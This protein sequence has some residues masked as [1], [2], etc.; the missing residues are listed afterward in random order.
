[1]ELVAYGPEAWI[2][3]DLDEPWEWA[4]AVRHAVIPGVIE[5][6]PGAHS[7]AVLCRRDRAEQV[8]G[9]L[10][11]IR[12]EASRAPIRATSLDVVYDREQLAAVGRLA[13]LDADA[14]VFRHT[15]ATYRVQFLA[16]RPG[17]PFLG[18]LDGSLQLA[19]R[20]TAD[21]P[22]PAGTVLLRGPMCSVLTVPMA[23]DAYPIG[24]VTQPLWSRDATPMAKLHAGEHVRFESV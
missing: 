18:P 24:R 12:S 14:I 23:T 16:E 2:A 4:S 10:R 7:V 8:A 13:G 11:S 21:T 15:A 17:S 9:R 5:V 19:P 3:M 22:L 20:E 1:M 6:Q